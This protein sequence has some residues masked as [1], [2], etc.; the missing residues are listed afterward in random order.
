MW[1][2]GNQ[3]GS[4]KTSVA[5]Y[6]AS[7]SSEV[8][9]ADTS[10]LVTFC[11]FYYIWDKAFSY[12][13]VI[14]INEYFGWELASL[15]MLAP[16]LDR[17]NKDWPEKPVLV[18]ELG[19]QAQWGFR[20]PHPKLAGAVRSIFSK[21]LSEDHQALFILSH[22]DTIWDKRSYVNGMV[23][24]AYADYMTSQ[25]KARTS[26]MPVGLNGCGIVTKDRE[27]KLSYGVVKDR[28]TAFRDRFAAENTIP[29]AK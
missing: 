22:L 15:G 14:A 10:R 5:D 19:A 6:I 23:V 4:Y 20:N 9:K 17:I 27:R 13:D 29:A 28:F 26:D 12:V 7:V 21:D 25:N 18:S 24:W 2:L 11:S 16:M 1:S 3:I 8:K